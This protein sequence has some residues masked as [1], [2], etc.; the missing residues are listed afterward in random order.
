MKYKWLYKLMKI[1][2]KNPDKKYYLEFNAGDIL[3]PHRDW[4]WN[5][6]FGKT[7]KVIS[8]IESGFKYQPSRSAIKIVTK[9]FEDDY[10]F[11]EEHKTQALKIIKKYKHG[12]DAWY[13]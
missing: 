3:A 7:D 13:E 12:G 11:Y 8:M 1:A 5:Y 10:V 6:E 2:I 4:N 9:K